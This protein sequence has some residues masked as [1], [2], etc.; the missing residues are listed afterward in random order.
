[1]LSKE[2]KENFI[3]LMVKE[4]SAKQRWPE[5]EKRKRRKDNTFLWKEEDKKAKNGF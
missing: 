5:A 4:I 2:K 3:T 1:M